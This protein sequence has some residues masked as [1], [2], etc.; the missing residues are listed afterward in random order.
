MP[1]WSEI[2]NQVSAQADLVNALRVIKSEYYKRLSEITGRNIISY[3]SGWMFKPTASDVSIN[4]KDK[5]AFM[6]A[7]H[8]LD[9][10]KGLDLILHTPGGDIAATESL[11]E[12]IHS[13]FEG[14]I[15][16]IIPQISMSAGSM[17]ALSCKDIVMGKQSSLGPIDPQIN[18]IACQ[19]V[20]DEFEDAKRDVKDNPNSIG[21]WQ[22][23]VAKY[24]P[25]FLITCKNAAEWAEQIAKKWIPKVHPQIDM[26][27]V[28][29]KFLNHKT[30]KAH[31]RHISAEECKAV[32]LSVVN[33]EDNNEMQDLILSIHHCYMILLERTNFVKIVENNIG[34]AYI[35]Q[36]PNSQKN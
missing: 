1:G 11:I 33:M 30:T 9:K 32:G 25:T 19:A 22:V 23:I 15:R 10:T 4:D 12:Y 34:S 21:L 35:I 24:N 13:I 14:N 8:N 31:N 16:A 27:A 5:N 26:D 18:G 36:L 2:L 20:L 28:L 17:I 6:S 3:Y 29:H 7:I